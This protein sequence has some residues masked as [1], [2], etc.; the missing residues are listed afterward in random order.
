MEQTLWRIHKAP[1]G[2]PRTGPRCWDTVYVWLWLAYKRSGCAIPISTRAIADD[3]MYPRTRVR[4]AVTWLETH[5]YIT[6]L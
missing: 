2:G 3:L 1:A 5:K 4:E 6:R